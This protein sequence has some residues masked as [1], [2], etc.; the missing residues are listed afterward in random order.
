MR[1]FGGGGGGWK[2]C[3]LGLH[4]KIDVDNNTYQ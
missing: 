2:L 4:N 3:A 1:G